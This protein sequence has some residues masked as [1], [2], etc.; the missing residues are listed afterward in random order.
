MDKSDV[1]GRSACL[2]SGSEAGF[3]A[4]LQGTRLMCVAKSTSTG[5]HWRAPSANAQPSWPLA[6][7]SKIT[8]RERCNLA[9]MSESAD[10]T[11]EQV[12]LTAADAGCPVSAEQLARW[13]RAG[14]LPR[15]RQRSLGRGL[16]TVTVYPP[17]TAS[18]VVAL[19]R[20][21]SGH[22]S[23]D[24]AAF[25]L[26]WEGFAVDPEKVWAP[27]TQVAKTL[28]SD[29]AT[30]RAGQGAVAVRLGGLADRRIGR[31]RLKRL[32]ATIR[33][34]AE[35]E[36]DP[37]TS[38]SD[39]E[40]PSMPPSIDELLDVVV[41]VLVGALRGLQSVELVNQTSFD[42]LCAA[43]DEAKEVLDAV[44]RWI[45]PMAWLWGR[46]GGAF[47]LL[48][49]IPKSIK[50]KD[51]PLLVFTF[52]IV[53]QI[54]PDDIRALIRT[55]PPPGLLQIAAFKAVH[56]HVPGADAVI[57]PRSIQAL[58]RDNQAAK[59]HRPKIDAFVDEHLD[60]IAT[61]L[62]AQPFSRSEEPS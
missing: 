10:Q 44:V 26:W 55:P 45:E 48:T 56:D 40:L 53:R 8:D 32:E 27:L 16:G 15:P 42:E 54:V 49:D 52:L 57:N 23:L 22:R 25:Q 11:R 2:T 14:L 3:R 51:L 60:E 31:Q 39:L 28:D 18:Q 6:S 35:K 5:S 34:A 9:V 36:T 29:L 12:L 43:R 47:Q 37:V 38:W 13:H 19:C 41:P 17:G 20:I 50:P 62:S 7:G 46:K 4:R 21:R 33:S 61:T 30:I 24:R 58:Y 59:R 1:K